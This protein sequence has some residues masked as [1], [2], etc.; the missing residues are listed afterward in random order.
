MEIFFMYLLHR[1]QNTY[2]TRI[3]LKFLFCVICTML[4]MH[5][6]NKIN[7]SW[8]SYSILQ[9]RYNFVRLLKF[10]PW[11][12][13]LF[14]AKKSYQNYSSH[15]LNKFIYKHHLSY[16]ILRARW[17]I[18]NFFWEIYLCHRIYLASLNIKLPP[19]IL[20]YNYRW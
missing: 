20:F 5:T 8:L 16:C 11:F 13:R 6:T 12:F 4:K 17:N 18:D 19:H 2:S 3:S 10:I 15:K 14:Y 1:I 7:S 9:E